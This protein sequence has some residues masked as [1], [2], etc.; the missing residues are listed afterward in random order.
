MGKAFKKGTIV[1][2]QV[3]TDTKIGKVTGYKQIKKG[4]EWGSNAIKIQWYL[5]KIKKKTGIMMP[6]YLRIK[7]IWAMGK[8]SYNLSDFS[9]VEKV[10][11]KEPK[12]PAWKVME[13]D[14]EDVPHVTD[15]LAE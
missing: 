3:K 1:K 12:G 5:L 8:Y 15:F 14:P 10:V 6:Y 4:E 2:V 7:E 9:R 13:K 11:G